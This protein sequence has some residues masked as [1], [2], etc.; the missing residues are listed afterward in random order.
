MLRIY[1]H[2]PGRPEAQL[3]G[4]VQFSRLAGLKAGLDAL[5]IPYEY[6]PSGLPEAGDRVLVISDHEWLREIIQHKRSGIDFTL[7]TGPIFEL[8]DTHR[9][10]KLSLLATMQSSPDPMSL[11]SGLDTVFTDPEVDGVLCAGAWA[12][13]GWRFSPQRSH[14]I[15]VSHRYPPRVFRIAGVLSIF[16]KKHSERR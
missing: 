2:S 8:E 12:K 7:L 13:G 16:T 1:T 14:K 11:L 9:T 5:N 4:L 10:G 3:N 15:C 6:Q